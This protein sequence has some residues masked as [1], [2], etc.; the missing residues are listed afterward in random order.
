MSTN[1]YFAPKEE[2]LIEVS[3]IFPYK[4]REELLDFFKLMIGRR[5]SN[6]PPIFY[7]SQYYSSVS[8][9]KEFYD[10]N[11]D[12]LQ[13]ENEYGEILTWNDLLK[14]LVHWNKDIF[15]VDE[16]DCETT[17]DKEGY[18]FLPNHWR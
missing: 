7:K 3:K 2:K 17:V 13:I 11:K 15:V 18:R 6:R 1:Y 10:T 8:E 12:S 5:T 16:F 14:E 4:T 9:I